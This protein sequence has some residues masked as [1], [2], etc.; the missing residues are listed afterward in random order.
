MF[1]QVLVL[2]EVVENLLPKCNPLLLGGIN[3]ILSNFHPSL[4]KYHVLKVRV[5]SSSFVLSLDPANDFVCEQWLDVDRN[6][7]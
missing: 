7:D 4:A 1:T 5:C 3:W 2:M 6:R